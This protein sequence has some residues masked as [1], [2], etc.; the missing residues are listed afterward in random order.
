MT[1]WCATLRDLMIPTATMQDP[2]S[3]NH[4]AEA[5]LTGIMDPAQRQEF[6]A[7]L[8]SCAH[9]QAQVA[10]LRAAHAPR[11]PPATKVEPEPS[12][13]AAKARAWQLLLAALVTLILGF[14]LGWSLWQMAHR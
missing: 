14:A 7:H 11:P 4:A 2:S 8:A 10:A 3:E 13:P 1:Y 9:C 5:W 12:A 6:E